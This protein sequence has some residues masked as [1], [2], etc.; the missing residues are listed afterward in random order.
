MTH[1]YER[2]S[3]NKKM[4]GI[5]EHKEGRKKTWRRER[6]GRNKENK[7][8]EMIKKNKERDKERGK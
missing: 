7:A 1:Q 3:R 8:R 6:E 2:K 4:V 5:Q